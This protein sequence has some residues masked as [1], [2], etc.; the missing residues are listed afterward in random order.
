MLDNPFRHVLV[1]LAFLTL[2]ACGGGSDSDSED[3]PTPTPEPTQAPQTKTG[4][5]VDS[6]VVNI[7]YSTETHMGVTGSDGE[8]EYEEGETVTFAI[9]G[10]SLPSA[11]AGQVVTPLDL[12][13]T[14]DATDNVVVNISR[15]LQTL[16]ADGDP[17]NGITITAA[18]NTITTQVDFDVTVEAFEINSDVLDVIIAGGQD[19][20]PS[21]LVSADD[22]IAHLNSTLEQVTAEAGIVGVWIQS[23]RPEIHNGESDAAIATLLDDGTYYFIEVNEIN[24]GDDWEYGTYTYQ[25]GTLSFTSILDYNGSIG[26][27]G[28]Q[29]EVT[30]GTDS[31]TF[32]TLDAEESGNYT[33]SRV[34]VEG[35]GIVG[36]WTFSGAL[37][38]KILFVFAADGTYMAVQPYEVDDDTGFEWGTYTNSNGNVTVNIAKDIGASLLGDE[39]STA[40]F[41]ATVD[42]DVMTV[43]IDNETVFL[44]RF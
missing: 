18:A 26:P 21:G 10:L 44:Q 27:A 16:D 23:A 29:I 11:P 15:L 30:L 13:G 32:P 41:S 34:D 35:D 17:S 7:M 42:G 40:S 33:F 19:A 1:S 37:E 25:N 39:S 31:F 6:A 43:N 8:F 2:A 12:A 9:G 36:V 3:D 22:A 20:V 28:A 4:R 14:D 5:F 24:D 38:E